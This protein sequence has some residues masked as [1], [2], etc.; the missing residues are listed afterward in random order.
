MKK[1]NT[2]FYVFMVVSD[3][4]DSKSKSV[5]FFSLDLQISHLERFK[6]I[7]LPFH[8]KKNTL[9]STELIPVFA[10]VETIPNIYKNTF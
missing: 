2:S 6:F 7:F 8:P 3:I 4:C 1:N 5:I 9:K 10:L